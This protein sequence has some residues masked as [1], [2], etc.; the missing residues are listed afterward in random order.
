MKKQETTQ[1]EQPKVKHS[2]FEAISEN[3]PFYDFEKQP[4]FIG[5]Y[6]NRITL[7]EKEPF[8]VF[9]MVDIQTGAGERVFITKSHAIEKAVTTAK[10]KYNTLNDVVFEFVFQ[11]KTEVNGKPYNQ[12]KTWCCTLEQYQSTL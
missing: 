12:F 3:L 1:V 8:E 5:I 9:I 10:A 7:G 2:P 6:E 11:G 4:T